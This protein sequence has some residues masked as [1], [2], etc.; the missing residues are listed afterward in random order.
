MNWQ[1]KII[2]RHPEE[3]KSRAP[4]TPNL[5]S[6]I[7][8]PFAVNI[9]RHAESSQTLIAPLFLSRNFHLSAFYAF[10]RFLL[11]PHCCDASWAFVHTH[12]VARVL[13]TAT[14]HYL[15]S[16]PLSTYHPQMYLHIQQVRTHRLRRW[17]NWVSEGRARVGV[18]F[19]YTHKSARRT[20]NA[21]SACLLLGYRQL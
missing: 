11:S 7:V 3:K 10:S 17:G 18:P 6:Q 9:H 8:A 19:Y 12:S 4:H 1:L 13:H 15:R 2:W 14:P 5:F 21:T 20:N 16:A